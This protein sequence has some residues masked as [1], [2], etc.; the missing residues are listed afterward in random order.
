VSKSTV[1]SISQLAVKNAHANWIAGA[2]SNAPIP[3]SVLPRTLTTAVL[4]RDIEA[5]I[6]FLDEIVFRGT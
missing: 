3:I 6:P 4:S 2:T 1:Y 5:A